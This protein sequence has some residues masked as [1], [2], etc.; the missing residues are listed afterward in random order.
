M[1]LI[2]PLLFLAAPALAQDCP[3]G[4][5]IFAHPMVL[6]ETVCVPVAP[7]R[8][9]LVD[10]EAIPAFLLGIETVTTN[11]Y[12]D[13]FLATYPGAVPDGWRDTVVD[14]G[15]LPEADFESVAAAAPD[16]IV[17][18]SWH[19]EANEKL[20]AIAPTV[21]LSYEGRDLHWTDAQRA[22]A[23]LFGKEAELSEAETALEARMA[24][25]RD[26]L[27][28][29]RPTFSTLQVGS[30]PTE[31]YV[32]TAINFAPLFLQELGFVVAPGVMNP[33]DAGLMG[34]VWYY[35]LS[36]ERITD[37]EADYI[38]FR[39]GY[40]EQAEAAFRDG[41]LWQSLAALREGR[42][43]RPQDKEGQTWSRENLAFAHIMLDDLYRDVLGLSP[44]PTANPYA[45]WQIAE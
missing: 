35:T 15:Y 37:V 30:T 41:P 11:V 45:L 2:L 23:A 6:G 19:P 18:A 36:P 10:A 33:E 12:F 38:L 44:P 34:S 3:D 29:R 8:V 42:I 31:L 27:G 40:D 17:S 39:P 5:R 21:V 25:F 7:A 1:R 4:Q 20:A 32:D 43:I 13:M 9:A 26:R 22:V 24:D 16:L 14:V 28:D